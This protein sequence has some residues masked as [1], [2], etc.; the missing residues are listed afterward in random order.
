MAVRETE[1]SLAAVDVYS[2]FLRLVRDGA[3][4]LYLLLFCDG[5]DPDDEGYERLELAL[6]LS[7]ERLQALERGELDLRTAYLEPEQGELAMAV[8][9]PDGRESLNFLPADE[10]FFQ[11]LPGRV[12]LKRRPL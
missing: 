12:L 10:V 9:W 11:H 8:A 1:A 5:P 2:D 6:P 4:Q 7:A 3:G